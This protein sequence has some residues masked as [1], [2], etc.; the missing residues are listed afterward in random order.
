MQSSIK[1][2]TY[3][4][5]CLWYIKTITEIAEG[6]RDCNAKKYSNKGDRH[7]NK[8]N[9]HPYITHTPQLHEEIVMVETCMCVWC[10]DGHPY[11]LLQFL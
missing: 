6:I 7:D 2:T 9:R 5:S 3:W 1:A 4:T 10:R 11:F 8:Y